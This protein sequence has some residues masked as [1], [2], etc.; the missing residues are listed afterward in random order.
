MQ[1]K[2]SFDDDNEKCH[3]IGNHCQYTGKHNIGVLFIIS[4]T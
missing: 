1:K 3:Q 2:Y 4:V